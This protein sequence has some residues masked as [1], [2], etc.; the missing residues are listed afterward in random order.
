MAFAP[1]KSSSSGTSPCAINWWL[2][3]ASGPPSARRPRE[4]VLGRSPAS[5]VWRE[6][7]IDPSPSYARKPSCGGF[8]YTGVGSGAHDT[9]LEENQQGST[10]PDLPHGRREPDLWEHHA[11]TGKLLKLGFDISERTVSRW[12]KRA[13][14]DPDPVRRWLPYSPQPPRSNRCHGLFHSAHVDAWW[15]SQLRLTPITIA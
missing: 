6:E 12:V 7:I 13:S 14:H 10:R 15:A 3:M 2:F 4:I 1:G 5:M 8:T 11:P 9:R